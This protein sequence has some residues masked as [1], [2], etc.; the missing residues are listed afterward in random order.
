VEG[1]RRRRLKKN[2]DAMPGVQG[3][4]ASHFEALGRI[5]PRLLIQLQ[6]T[7]NQ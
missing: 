7:D 3:M 4:V 6:R 1:L 5:V 2:G